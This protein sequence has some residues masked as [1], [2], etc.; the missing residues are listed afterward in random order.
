MFELSYK[1]T[2]PLAYNRAMEIGEQIRKIRTARGLSIGELGRQSGVSKTTISQWESGKHK[3]GFDQLRA[4]LEA[5]GVTYDQLWQDLDLVLAEEAIKKER[6]DS[7]DIEAVLKADPD[8][9]DAEIEVIMRIV[10]S[11]EREKKRELR[12]P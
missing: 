11:K 10:Q 1:S 8:L 9:T 3:P 4:V 7:K 5:L 12:F 2:A 6:T